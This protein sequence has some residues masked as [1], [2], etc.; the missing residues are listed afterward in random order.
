MGITPGATITKGGVAFTWP[1]VPA[2]TPDNVAM[3]GKSISVTGS[4]STLA[5]SA[6]QRAVHRAAP[7]TR[8]RTR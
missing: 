8:H 4:G 5:S 1:N 2:G 3:Q 7:T 6:R